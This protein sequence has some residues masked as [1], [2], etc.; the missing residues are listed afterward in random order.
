MVLKL[1]IAAGILIVKEA[2]GT[3][4]DMSK[5]DDDNINIRAASSYIYPEMMEK[6]DKF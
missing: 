4:N 2:G 6:I 3:L 1:D 5:Y